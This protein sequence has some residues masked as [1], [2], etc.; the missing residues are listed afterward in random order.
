MKVA[1]LRE[2]LTGL[3]D[4]DEVTITVCVDGEDYQIR[5]EEGIRAEGMNIDV[6]HPDLDKEVSTLRK[7]RNDAF[8]RVEEAAQL[9]AVSEV[10]FD[11]FYRD[12]G[13]TRQDLEIAARH[14]D[15]KRALLRLRSK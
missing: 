11:L 9:E 1:H 6:S 5:G 15:P 8:E 14:A 2:F 13:V 10:M 12:A 7:D 4:D 3:D